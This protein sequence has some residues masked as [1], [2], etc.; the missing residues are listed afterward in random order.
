MIRNRRMPNKLN[1]NI[2]T[3]KINDTTSLTVLILCHEDTQLLHKIILSLIPL[4]WVNKIHLIHTSKVFSTPNHEKISIFH[5]PTVL[6]KLDFAKVRNQA[7][8]NCTTNWFL[9]LDSD[10]L[11]DKKA[12]EDIKDFLR[13]PGENVAAQLKRIDFFKGTE[14]AFGETA[15]WCKIRLGKVGFVTFSRPIHET[16]QVSQGTIKT[17][18]GNI[19]HYPH[20]SVA[21]FVASVSNYACQDA[22]LRTWKW[23]SCFSLLFLPTAKFIYTYVFLRGF[24]D[25][26]AGLVYA[27]VMSL[28]SLFVRIYMFEAYAQKQQK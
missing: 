1:P 20:T 10:E 17:L 22:Q 25:G 9:F 8:V 26:Y 11:L 21:E 27:S 16:A 2:L 18:S 3:P 6:E 12:K 28:H 7:I 14:L 24:L 5:T 15:T 13:E 4:T 23:Y 19:L